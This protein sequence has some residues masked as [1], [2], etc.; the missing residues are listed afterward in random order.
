MGLKYGITLPA[1]TA[2]DF[3]SFE[4]EETK[5]GSVGVDAVDGTST[6]VY[7]QGDDISWRVREVDDAGLKGE[8]SDP[9]AFMASDTIPPGKAGSVTAML[10]EEVPD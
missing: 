10:L 9:Y 8:W 7:A 2:P 3:A 6:F 4:L 1:P 5:N